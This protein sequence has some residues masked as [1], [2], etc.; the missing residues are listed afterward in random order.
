MRQCL[1]NLWLYK[2]FAGSAVFSRNF[3]LSICDFSSKMNISNITLSDFL[4]SSKKFI[5]TFRT[6]FL[7]KNNDAVDTFWNVTCVHFVSFL[8]SETF[9][10]YREIWLK[11]HCFFQFL[12]CARVLEFEF[13]KL[14]LDFSL[15]FLNNI[16]RFLNSPSFL[17]NLPIFFF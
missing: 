8:R 4:D 2:F 17:M 15:L 7:V 5:S 10:S 3:I 13:L 1:W 9:L 14:L 11:M 6:F 16:F 12:N